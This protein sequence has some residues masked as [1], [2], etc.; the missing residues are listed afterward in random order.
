[1]SRRQAS[2]PSS[3][4][5]E[6]PA[7]NPDP[8]GDPTLQYPDG[9]DA[10]E[11]E[12]QWHSDSSAKANC[13]SRGKGCQDPIFSPQSVLQCMRLRLSGGKA[14]RR[15]ILGGTDSLRERMFVPVPRCWNDRARQAL[16][17]PDLKAESKA[18]Q[19]TLRTFLSP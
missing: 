6:F 1:M 8:E 11:R 18:F 13:G 3:N 17:A 7:R 5:V 4:P 16:L 19:K 12:R 10:V 15:G 14:A 9:V 2:H